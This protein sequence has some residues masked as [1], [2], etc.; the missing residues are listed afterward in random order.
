LPAII[1]FALPGACLQAIADTNE[2]VYIYNSG[3]TP[4]LTP[5]DVY[6]EGHVFQND[7]EIGA[8]SGDGH[9]VSDA[10]GA[11]IGLISPSEA[12]TRELGQ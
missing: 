12:S 4:V 5:N 2:T 10:T 11:T 3:G 1:G 8:V 6:Q 7:V 9:I